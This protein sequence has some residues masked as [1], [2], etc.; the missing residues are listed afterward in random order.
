[1]L[2]VSKALIF[3]TMLEIK[4][5]QIECL[6]D[7]SLSKEAHVF[8]LMF[9]KAFMTIQVYFQTAIYTRLSQTLYAMFDLDLIHT[10]FVSRHSDT[11]LP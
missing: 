4:S 6:H 10:F 2:F 8:P 7:M 11:F 9:R 5:L 1:M 3:M